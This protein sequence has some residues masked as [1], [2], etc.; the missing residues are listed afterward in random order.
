MIATFVGEKM[1]TVLLTLFLER[2]LGNA[3][4]YLSHLS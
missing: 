3:Y 2:I 1:F 4:V